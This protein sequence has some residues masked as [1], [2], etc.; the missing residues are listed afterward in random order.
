MRVYTPSGKSGS[1]LNRLP[2]LFVVMGV[3][4]WIYG[5]VNFNN[6]LYFTQFLVTL[7]F[8][9]ILMLFLNL[10]ITAARCRNAALASIISLAGCAFALYVAWVTFEHALINSALP[11]GTRPLGL[12]EL[13]LAPKQ[14][15]GFAVQIQKTGWNSIAGTR[16]DGGILRAAWA[17][18]IGLVLLL[19]GSVI[20]WHINEKFFC[21]NCNVWG[22]ELP[23][24]PLFALPRGTDTRKRLEAGDFKV[25]DELP[26]QPNIGN[27]PRLRVESQQ[28]NKCGAVVVK[29]IL[30]TSVVGDTGQREKKEQPLTKWVLFKGE[31]VHELPRALGLG[32]E[33]AIASSE[34]PEQNP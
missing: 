12:M 32:A 34:K 33:T 11:P 24:L 18:E 26:L 14:V 25:L 2:F 13:F 15:W 29:A 6:P 1:L 17:L 20:R 7:I 5:L 22:Q 27:A 16:I 10:I 4:G 8:D 3:S 19:A 30:M 28:C 9:F 31:A 23:T 21:E